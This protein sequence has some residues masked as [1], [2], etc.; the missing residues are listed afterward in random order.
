MTDKQKFMNEEIGRI[1]AVFMM[2][3]QGAEARELAIQ[4]KIEAL[5]VKS[6]AVQEEIG[7]LQVEIANFVA[8]V[9]SKMVA[10]IDLKKHIDSEIDRH[11]AALE[12]TT[13]GQIAGAKE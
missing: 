9:N 11:R 5:Q 3:M 13:Q 8:R 12:E 4:N 2:A 6:G 7:E 1:G 10:L